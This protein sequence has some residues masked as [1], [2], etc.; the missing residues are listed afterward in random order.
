M[1][2]KEKFIRDLY[3]LVS[4]FEGKTGA[5]IFKIEFSRIK[6]TEAGDLCDT[7]AITNCNLEMR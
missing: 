6:T 2:P 3:N 4:D 7:T 5:E 1:T